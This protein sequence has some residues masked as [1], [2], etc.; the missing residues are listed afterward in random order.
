MTLTIRDL[1]VSYG[2]KPVLTGVEATIAAGTFRGVL[3]ANGCGKSTL[4]KSLIGHIR[5]LRGSVQV[6]G[7]DLLAMR[8]LQRA[9]HLG[10]VGQSAALSS[11]GRSLRVHELISLGVPAKRRRQR[12]EIVTHYAQRLQLDDL[13]DRPLRELS[14]G[15]AQRAHLA[16]ALAQG[17]AT[18]L[19]DEPISALDLAFQVQVMALLRELARDEGRTVVAVLHDLDMAL[20]Y[21]DDV[22]V[23]HHGQTV[24]E[25]ASHLI[26]ESLIE[27]VYGLSVSLLR[28]GGRLHVVPHDPRDQALTVSDLAAIS[29]G[30]DRDQH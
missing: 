30:N 26:T 17:V 20:H 3:G 22:M 18:I 28:Y 13:L 15:Q 6:A 12:E 10:Y 14:G 21:C 11:T 25:G 24:A 8:V 5:P 2:A 27:E 7:H 9:E 1:H 23:L 19:L 4:L 16:R 29:S